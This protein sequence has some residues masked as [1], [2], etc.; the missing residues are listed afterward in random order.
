MEKSLTTKLHKK[1]QFYSLQM[2]EGMSIKS[3]IDTFKSIILD[4][5][6][7]DIEIDDEDQPLKLR[8]SLLPSLTLSGDITLWQ[9]EGDSGIY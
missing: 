5:E 9:D 7:V 4:L 2:E 8:F 3:H 1:L 6:K